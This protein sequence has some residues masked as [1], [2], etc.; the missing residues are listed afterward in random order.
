MTLCF[1]PSIPM[2]NAKAWVPFLEEQKWAKN[3]VYYEDGLSR[4]LRVSSIPMTLVIGRDGTIVS[5][6]NGYDPERFVDM[7]TE[8][9]NDALK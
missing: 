4:A 3:R 6:M 7:L 8:R 5:R 9:I 1:W 2:K